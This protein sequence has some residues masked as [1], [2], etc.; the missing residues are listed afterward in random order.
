M[1]EWLFILPKTGINQVYNI[2]TINHLYAV[3]N[4][5]GFFGHCST[6]QPPTTAVWGYRPPQVG[7]LEFEAPD[8]TRN[9]SQAFGT[10]IL[11]MAQK[12][13]VH[14]LRLVNDPPIIYQGSFLSQ[15]VVWDVWTINNNDWVWP[16]LI[17]SENWWQK[18]NGNCF[19]LWK[20]K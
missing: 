11:L 5:H 16:S 14:Q 2:T 17:K 18:W 12:P 10:N 6:F 7:S 1:V 8:L 19:Y 9:P 3:N 4:Y 15:V 13:G 20:E